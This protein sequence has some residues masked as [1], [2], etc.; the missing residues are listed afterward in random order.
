MS[1]LGFKQLVQTNQ[2]RRFAHLV[3][4]EQVSGLLANFFEGCLIYDVQEIDARI[5]ALQ[6]SQ[7]VQT[8]GRLSNSLV[9]VEHSLRSESQIIGILVLNQ[10]PD[11]D[12]IG[13]PPLGRG[14]VSRQ[15]IGTHTFSIGLERFSKIGVCLLATTMNI[16]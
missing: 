2:R 11:L 12:R 4:D 3:T 8:I 9:T 7:Q 10:L 16:F 15:Q 5:A 14:P 1:D 6:T 13:I